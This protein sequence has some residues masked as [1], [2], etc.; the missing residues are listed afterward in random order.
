M[1]AYPTTGYIKTCE[2][3]RE[4]FHTNRFRR[5]FC[6]RPCARRGSAR[7][8]VVITKVCPNCGRS[9]Q[10]RP[11]EDARYLC[12]TRQCRAQRTNSAEHFW[13]RVEKSDG[14]W[15]WQGARHTGGYGAVCADGVQMQAHRR[16]WELTYGPIPKGLVVCHRCDNRP[17]VRPD[18]LFLGTAKENCQDM[19]AKG[20]AGFG[21][22]KNNTCLITEEVAKA[23]L[24]SKGDESGADVARS[25]GVST[26]IVYRIWN[27]ITWKHLPRD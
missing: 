16:S 2:W 21:G 14:C 1:R 23:I 8:N 26:S 7:P 12:C 19:L 3:C 24:R 25:F 11:C 9:F 13:E 20:R 27:G 18:H 6:S 17:C 5:R 15:E 22:E 10:V 4:T